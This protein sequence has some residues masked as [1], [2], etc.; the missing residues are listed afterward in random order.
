LCSV[1][2]NIR[3]SSSDAIVESAVGANV[4]GVTV[5]NVVWKIGVVLFEIGCYGSFLVCGYGEVIRKA[6]GGAEEWCSR[7]IGL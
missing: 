6:T 4:A 1:G 7:E 3:E 2:G 5:D